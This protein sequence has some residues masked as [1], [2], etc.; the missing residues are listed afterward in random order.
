MKTLKRNPEKFETLEL[1]SQLSPKY[2]FDLRDQ[3]SI[4]E[5]SIKIKKSIEDSKNNKN[6]IFG[7]RTESMFEFV[8]RT[9][10]KAT[11]LKQEDSGAVYYTGED[12]A[13]PDYRI[14]V[15]NKT[16]F[17]EVKN[18]NKDH[19]RLKKE[20]I[21]KL[22]R[23]AKMFNMELK[24]AIY[25]SHKK[26][27]IL[28]SISS[29][30]DDDIYLSINYMQAIKLSEMSILGD[31]HVVC[32]SKKID[33]TLPIEE[34]E[35]NEKNEF[36]LNVNRIKIQCNETEVT[37]N[38]LKEIILYLLLYGVTLQPQITEYIDKDS[39]LFRITYPSEGNIGEVH[40]YGNLSFISSKVFHQAT[41]DLLGN[42]TSLNL[43]MEPIQFTESII[44]YEP[45][46]LFRIV[47]MHYHLG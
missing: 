37:D 26:I 42:I 24:F 35:Y 22:S 21:E 30:C 33:V 27:W 7:K 5:F 29:F 11:F 38:K 18:C 43:Q 12:I 31:F 2:K 8:I 1:F 16:F 28:L 34:H 25:F 44:N 19:F 10:G 6:I 13:L 45:N 40:N 47:R 39:K 14:I 3:K 4:N 20:Y 17:I 23:Y 41:S 36:L 15:E 46:E 32:V 9:L